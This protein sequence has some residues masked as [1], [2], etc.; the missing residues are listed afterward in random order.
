MVV[1]FK[2]FAPGHALGAGTLW[3]VEEIPGLVAGA[4]ATETLSRGYWPSYNVPYFTEVYNRSG[5]NR[6]DVQKGLG[7][8]ADY[9]LAP[10]AKIFRRDQASV[11]DMQSFKVGEQATAWWCVVVH[12]RESGRVA[13]SRSSRYS[14]NR[15]NRSSFRGVCNARGYSCTLMN[16]CKAR[17]HIVIFSPCSAVV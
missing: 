5:Y 2:Q 7:F 3:V 9:E 17:G 15:A 6:T 11:V 13:C 1:D 10:R 16:G 8:E 14:C 4:D 12:R